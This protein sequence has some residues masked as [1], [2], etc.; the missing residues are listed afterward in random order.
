[1]TYS[2]TTDN[3]GM[4][5]N[6]LAAAVGVTNATNASSAGFAGEI[7]NKTMSLSL[8]S[9]PM[10]GVDTKVYW[11]WSRK[12]N[13]S[14]QMT[15]TPVAGSNCNAVAGPARRSSSITKRTIRR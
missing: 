1:M 2:K 5:P 15:F 9:Q 3:V 4:L 12:D 11:N 6:M 10:R 14:T 8:N 7:V 13:N